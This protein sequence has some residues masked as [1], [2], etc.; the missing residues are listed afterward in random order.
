[1]EGNAAFGD[2]G[3]PGLHRDVSHDQLDPKYAAMTRFTPA[4]RIKR[5]LGHDEYGDI[6]AR[7]GAPRSLD[8]SK[9][10]NLPEQGAAGNQQPVRPTNPPQP[11]KKKP[12]TPFGPGQQKVNEKFASQQQAKLMYATA[13]GAD[14]GVSKKVAKEFIKKSHGQKVSKLPKKVKKD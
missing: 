12:M 3:K 8:Y 13:G 9:K 2:R 11:V 4:D 7:Q 14:T 6:R 10:P 5:R 1:M